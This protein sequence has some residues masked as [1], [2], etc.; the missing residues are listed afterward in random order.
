MSVD[1]A[2][3]KKDFPI[4][5]RKVRGGHSLVYLDSGAT[6]HKP[7]S[8]IQAEVDFYKNINA[9]VHRGAH[10]LAEDASEAYESAR[11]NVAQFIGAIPEELIFTKS[12]TESLNVLAY[13]LGNSESAINIKSGDEIVVTEVEHHANLIPWQQLAKRTGAKLRWLQVLPDGRLDLSNIDEVITNKCR[14]VAITHQSNVL[15]TILPVSKISATARAVGALVVLDACQTAPHFP[16]NVKNLDVDFIVFSGHKMLGPTGI[17]VLWGKL[18]L[19]EQL[20]PAF[21][22]G[23][24]VDSVSMDEATWAKVPR[25]FEAGV[26]NMAQ[27]VGLS[28]AINYLRIVG[29]SNIEQ[30]EQALTAK[31]I[32][33]LQQISGVK[34]IGPL[35]GKDRG[36]VVSFVVD[37]VHPHDVG[38]V[39]DQYGIAVRTGHHCAWPLMKKLNLIGTTRASLHLY[40]N[41]SDIEA[42]FEG[43]EKVKSYFK[44]V[45]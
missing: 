45:K 4:F 30:H 32:S 35:D 14:V 24:M 22:G 13:S 9:A 39:L 20:E 26:P 21:F 10:L 7:E 43:L 18:N 27:A 23:S 28:A 33:G 29:M 41:E 8:V 6:S 16:I 11:A 37:G 15:G 44:V 12:A 42:L 19:L 3:F 17:G 36:G 40:N 38:Q 34:V 5:D 25:K 31:L 1:L 2:V